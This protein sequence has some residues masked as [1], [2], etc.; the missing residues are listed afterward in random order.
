MQ[1]A[2]ELWL[3]RHGQTAWNAVGR[4]QGHQDVPL[5]SAGVWQAN[6]LAQ[7]FVQESVRR[8]IDAVIASPLARAWLTAQPVAQALDLD[9]H[10]EPRLRERCFGIFE[11]HTLEDIALHW[12]DAFALWRARDMAWAMPEGE[13]AQQF[14][15]R[16]LEALQAIATDWAGKTVVVVT[17]GGVLDVAYR[18]AQGLSWDAPRLHLMLNAAINRMRLRSDPLTLEVVDWGDAAH[19]DEEVD[20][21]C[22]NPRSGS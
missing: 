14:I 2:T 21:V 3:I 12:P 18:H 7:R 15:E 6:R 4:V 10:A 1:P 11:G 16:T 13:S 5:S 20:P 17:H 9:L 22:G 8:Q 19:L